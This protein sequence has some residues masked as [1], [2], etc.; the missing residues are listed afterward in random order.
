MGFLGL[1]YGKESKY[2]EQNTDLT[3]NETLISI[4]CNIFWSFGQTQNMGQKP[5]KICCFSRISNTFFNT[6]KKP[7]KIWSIPT[8]STFLDA[9]SDFF[10]DF[11]KREKKQ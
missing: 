8:Y 7:T 1:K 2:F 9:N 11:L 3:G 6:K 5:Q 4:L 10:G